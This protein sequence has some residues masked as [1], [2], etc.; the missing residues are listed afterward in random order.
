MII[1]YKSLYHAREKANDYLVVSNCSRA[2]DFMFGRKFVT[3]IGCFGEGVD[4]VI[5]SMGFFAGLGRTWEVCVED[6]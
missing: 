5:Q 2:Y 4:W 6:V 3:M 1:I